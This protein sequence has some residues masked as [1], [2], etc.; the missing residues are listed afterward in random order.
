M[1]GDVP[2]DRRA[3]KKGMASHWLLRLCRYEATSGLKTRSVQLETP[4]GTAEG[5]RI[6]E[7]VAIIPILRAGLGMCDAMLELLPNA[8]VHHI[9]MYRL[10]G[11]KM[12]V[13]YYNR[14]PK[15]KPCDVAYV[16]DPLIASSMYEAL[17]RQAKQAHFPTQAN[18]C[19][20]LFIRTRL[21]T[22]SRRPQVLA[23]FFHC[24]FGFYALLHVA[25]CSTLQATVS[26]VKAWGC[27][28]VVVISVVGTSEGLAAICAKHPDVEIH[29]VS[30]TDQLNDK[31]KVVPGIGDSGDR[32]FDAQLGEGGW[33]LPSTPGTSASASLL[34][35]DAAPFA[36]AVTEVAAKSKKAKK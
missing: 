24:V 21:L 8:A 13:Q 4:M 33:D 3:V 20:Y 35:R 29:L 27:K 36:A 11:T 17:T 12:P 19:V 10:P 25:L 34:K 31:G 2:F 26:Q 16:L 22:I 15:D 32:Q 7:R 5:S 9:G 30:G 6:D 28:K 1:L 23:I 14:L 18:S